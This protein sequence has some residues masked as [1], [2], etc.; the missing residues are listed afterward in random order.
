MKKLCM[1][2]TT[3]LSFTLGAQEVDLEPLKKELI[4]PTIKVQ[5]LQGQEGSLV[6]VKGG[7]NLYDPATGK[8]LDTCFGSSS[9]YM[10]PTT[11]GIKWG[12]E[13][14]DVYQLM[15][16][17]DK[18]ATTV[19]VGGVE[20]RGIAYLYHIKGTIGAVNEVSLED[21]TASTLSTHVPSHIAAKEALSAL[22]IAMRTQ[23]LTA[24][25]SAQNEF[26]DV[27][28][29]SF[30]YQGSAIER[31]DAPFVEAIRSTR[32]MVLK[33][34]DGTLAQIRWFAA[35]ESVAPMDKIQA[36]AGEGKDARAI[37]SQMF[38]NCTIS[39]VK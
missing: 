24:K 36:L 33:N 27:R 20:Y 38:P 12:Q 37:L 2:L 26:W 18:K 29:E 22:A 9:Y 11:E 21:F 35:G 7:Y 39:V 5:V 30:G 34:P 15:I 32:G 3:C 6:E 1:L 14:P 31:H 19:L 16:I 8:K 13:F 25:S 23:G 17:P 10:Y 28:R 4:K